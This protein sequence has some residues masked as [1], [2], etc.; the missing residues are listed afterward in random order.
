MTKKTISISSK[1]LP[2]EKAKAIDQWVTEGTLENENSK[3]YKEQRLTK[4]LTVTI[5]E[6]LHKKIKLY[7]V[8]NNINM[9]DKVEEILE[10]EFLNINN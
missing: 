6:E 2:N 8:K 7:C 1:P 4:K 10:K 5:S 3:I 9:L